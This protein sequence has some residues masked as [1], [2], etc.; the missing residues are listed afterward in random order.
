[1]VLAIASSCAQSWYECRFGRI[2]R[3]QDMRPLRA[4]PGLQQYPIVPA[5]RMQGPTYRCFHESGLYLGHLVRYY[6]VVPSGT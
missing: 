2:Q 6:V 1:M 4:V 3:W 5:S